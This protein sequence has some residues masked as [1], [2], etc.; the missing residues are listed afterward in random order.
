MCFL[1]AFVFYVPAWCGG[2]RN[3]SFLHWVFVSPCFYSTTPHHSRRNTLGVT[4]ETYCTFLPC[5]PPLHLHKGLTGRARDNQDP[6]QGA[7]RAGGLLQRPTSAGL[8]S[9]EWDCAPKDEK[10][11]TDCCLLMMFSCSVSPATRARSKRS[12]CKQ[13]GHGGA[14]GAAIAS[15]ATGVACARPWKTKKQHKNKPAYGLT[16]FDE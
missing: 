16:L 11:S 8:W 15:A 4:S 12:A 2:S 7:G 1:L 10:A 13:K 3:V 14:R 9:A 6:Q 5:L